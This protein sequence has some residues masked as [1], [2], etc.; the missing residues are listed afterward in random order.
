[1]KFKDNVYTEDYVKYS[2]NRRRSLIAQFR[3]GILLTQHIESG[4]FRNKQPEEIICP[5]CNTVVAD[6][7]HFV[8]ISE[9]YSQFREILCAINS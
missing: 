6:E 8:C 7:Y 4:R 2:K 9:E 5:I 3:L 1:M